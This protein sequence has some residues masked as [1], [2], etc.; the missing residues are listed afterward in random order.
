KKNID[1]ALLSLRL[2]GPRLLNILSGALNMPS[3]STVYRHA[4]RTYMRP[5]IAFP[6][7]DEVLANVESMCRRA[8]ATTPP[9]GVRGFSVLIDEIALEER[10][11]YSAAEDTLVGF[12]RE[13]TT[14]GET[15]NITGRPISHLFGLRKLLDSGEIHR[16][17]EATVV[18]IAPFGPSNYAPMVIMMSGTCKAETVD[19][20]LALLR[21]SYKSYKSSPY[22]AAA[23]GPIWSFATDGDACR[24]LALYRLCMTHTLSPPSPLYWELSHLELMNLA[25]GED[26]ITHD[27]DFKHEEKRFASALR[28]GKG[29]YINGTHISP[30]DIKQHLRLVPTISPSRL[31]ALFDN[32]DRQSVPKAHTLLKGIHNAS[33]SPHILKQPG[34]RPFVLLGELLQAFYAPHTTPSMNLSQQVISMAK[35]AFILFALFRIDGTR[36]ITPQLYYDIQA[37]IKNAMFCIAKTQLLDPSSSFYVIQL[38][39]D[40][41]ENLFGIY[42]T[43]STNR[44]PDLLQLAE[45]SSAAQEVD[46]ILAEYPDYDRKPYRLSVD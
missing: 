5:S 23:L 24:R 2:G 3:L 27:G 30:G 21:L 8:K 37:S 4:E 16:A 13:C 31:E 6:T 40:R 29:M 10:I 41:L 20:H 19:D 43:A 42:R 18:A 7:E 44:N 15:Q 22:G 11:R 46:N 25:C 34:L 38:G 33:Q 28:F 1:I 17:K 26:E 35:C 36:F 39:D 45:R 32:S 14:P 9:T 12:C